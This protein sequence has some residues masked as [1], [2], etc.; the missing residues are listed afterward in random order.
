MTYY[1]PTY[2]QVQR[3]RNVLTLLPPT[4]K[5]ST[6]KGYKDLQSIVLYTTMNEHEQA[7]ATTLQIS[8]TATTPTITIKAPLKYH[9]TVDPVNLEA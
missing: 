3:G 9:R 1:S 7:A 6:S 5:S 4:E 2:Y 8:G